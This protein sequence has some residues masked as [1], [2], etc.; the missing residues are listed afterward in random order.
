MTVKW[1]DLGLTGPHRVRDLWRQQ[2]LGTFDGG[3]EASVLVHG[4]VMVRIGAR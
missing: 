1:S 3:F 2:D 4:A